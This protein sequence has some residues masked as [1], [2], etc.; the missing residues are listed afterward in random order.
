MFKVTVS[1]GINTRAFIKFFE[2]LEAIY[3][4]EVFNRRGHLLEVYTFFVRIK[5]IKTPRLRIGLT[6]RENADLLTFTEE[7]LVCGRGS[8]RLSKID[9]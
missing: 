1:H 8:T 5:F 2:F 3:L 7:I 6:A 4:S 9:L